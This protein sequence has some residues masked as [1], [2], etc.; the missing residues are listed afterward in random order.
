MTSEHKSK[1]RE[2]FLHKLAHCSAVKTILTIRNTHSFTLYYVRFTWMYVHFVWFVMQI[3]WIAL[4]NKAL[5]AVEKIL[6]HSCHIAMDSAR[7]QEAKCHHI[8]LAVSSETSE[9]KS[10]FSLLWAEH[11][12]L[13]SLVAVIQGT[14]QQK[15]QGPVGKSKTWW[16]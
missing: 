14:W 3:W 2:I 4:K 15:F 13:Q 8:I 9:I 6:L 1:G 11:I 7:H 16:V 5:V 10:R 12:S